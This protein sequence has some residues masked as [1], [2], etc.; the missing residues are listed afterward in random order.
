MGNQSIRLEGPLNSPCVVCGAQDIRIFLEIHEVPI[1]CNMLFSTREEALRAPKADMHLGFC[2]HCGHLFNA[3]FKPDLLHYQG[4]YENSLHFSREF[5]KYAE[6]LAQ[7]LVRSYGLFGKEIIE[8]GC[9]QGEFLNLMCEA[10]QN[11]GLGFDPSQRLPSDDPKGNRAYKIVNDVYSDRHAHHEADLIVCRH[12][13][14][15]MAHPS[16]FLAMLRRNLDHRRGT[17]LYFE[18]PNGASMIRK[19]SVWDLIYEHCSYFSEKSLYRLFVETGFHVLDL[20]GA[21][22]DQFLCIEATLQRDG[23]TSD[24]V[25]YPETGITASHVLSFSEGYHKKLEG[26]LGEINRIHSLG[27]KMVLWGGGSKGVSLLNLLGIKHQIS[28]VVDINPRK[29]GTF[30]SGTG[31]EIISP[32]FFKRY[33]PD[34][35]F[36]MNPM[37]EREIRETL[38]AMG[39]EPALILL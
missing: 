31:H 22:G 34:T 30:V 13:L 11:R 32:D 33:K 10:G 25:K 14:E 21:F 4:A 1:H 12:V 15:H 38:T 20:Y 2:E 3:S 37:Y 39:M 28:H 19:G 35:V 8:I 9:G 23:V 6:A 16:E 5:R 29:H 27:R 24:Q 26:C 18:V 17:T 7:R 36:I